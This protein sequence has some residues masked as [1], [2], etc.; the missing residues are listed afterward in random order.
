IGFNLLNAPPDADPVL[1]FNGYGSA[2]TNTAQLANFELRNTSSRAIWLP[3]SGREFPLRAPF[4]ERPMAAQP[5]A[6]SARQTNVYSFSVGSFFMQGNKLPPGQK[7]LLEFPLASGRPASQVGVNYYVGTF[8]DGNDFLG[9]LG[10]RLLK[11][12]ASLKD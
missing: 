11:S 8:K 2:S 9:N 1:V 3:Y 10:T 5:P 6:N 7:L 12:N 4:L